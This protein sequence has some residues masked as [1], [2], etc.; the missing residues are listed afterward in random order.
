VNGQASKSF[1]KLGEVKE[2]TLTPWPYP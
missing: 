2:I 1:G